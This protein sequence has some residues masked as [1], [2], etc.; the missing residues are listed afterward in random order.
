MKNYD[1]YLDLAK[2]EGRSWSLQERNASD[3]VSSN[4]LGY[5][6]WSYRTL[7]VLYLEEVC[8]GSNPGRFKRG[9][10][11]LVAYHRIKTFI[12]TELSD[13][14]T[15]IMCC[16]LRKCALVPILVASREGGFW[17]GSL[18]PDINFYQHWAIMRCT[19]WHHQWHFQ[20]IRSRCIFKEVTRGSNHWT[21]SARHK[22]E[23]ELS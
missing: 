11:S 9:S 5:Q 13:V 16:I 19:L 4:I 7:T 18:S 6:D 23:I 1:W 14:D 17:S 20:N 22:F 2:L 8:P 12:N 10:P 3:S 15:I 21:L